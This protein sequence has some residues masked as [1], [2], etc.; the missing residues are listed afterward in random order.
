V[1]H[2]CAE[3][4]FDDAQLTPGRVPANWWVTSLA[5]LK[6]WASLAREM[7]ASDGRRPALVIGAD[8]ACIKEGKLIGTPRDAAEA[9]AIIRFLS[10]GRHSVVTGVALL[11]NDGR[12]ELF[13]AD[14]VVEVG[15]LSEEQI[16]A[17]IEG[18]SWEGK[19]GAYNLRERL[20]AGWPISFTGDPTAIM[21]LP[22][23]RLMPLLR[24]AGLADNPTD[25]PHT[26]AEG[27]GS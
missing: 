21:G 18:G 24:G 26:P 23:E 9:R 10:A 12:R 19:A 22:M 16:N 17:Y 25:S 2:Q 20:D 6:A 3:P 11:W 14:A 13:S 7:A 1:R 15:A 4:L 8:T 27:G 5:Y